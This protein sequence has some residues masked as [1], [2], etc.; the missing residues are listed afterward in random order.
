[1]GKTGG[2]GLFLEGLST[3]MVNPVGKMYYSRNFSYGK[4]NNITGNA[5]AIL[6]PIERLKFRSSFGLNAWFGHGRSWGPTYVLGSKYQ[7]NTD[8]ATQTMY[9]GS[10]IT[11]TNTL[12]YD[13]TVKEDHNFN[14]LVGSEMLK[15]QLNTNLGASKINTLFGHPDYAYLDNTQP[16]TTATD[17]S[18]WG[19]D[20]AA[21]GGGLL[22]YMARVS[23]NYKN[24]YMF[25]ATMRADGSS[26]FAEGNRWG[27]FPSASFG[28]NFTEEEFM[29]NVD[30]I[31]Y[32]KFR[33]SWGQN[34]N[35]NINNFVYSSNI[36][37]KQQ[38]YYLG[39]NKEVPGVAAVPANVPNP[40][41][42]W[43]TSE[44]LNFGIDARMFDSRMNVTFDWYNKVTK[45]WLVVAP[46]LGTF[47]A[48]APYVNGG[49]VRNRG[50][51]LSIGWNDNVGDFDYGITVSG[52]HNA[53]EV[54][55]LANAE[56]VINGSGSALAQN[57]SFVSRVEVGKPIGY[58][59]GFETDG[60][61]QNQEEVN[62]YVDA[63][64]NPIEIETE[65][66]KSRQPGDVRFV[67][68]NGDGVINDSDKVMIGS[69]QADL[70]L[71]I[72]LNASY[73]NFFFNTT[74]TG[75]FG[76]EVMQSYRSF[77]DRLTE[78]YTTAV[79][80]RWHGEGTSNT[81]PRLTYE[82]TANNLLISDLYVH[83]ADYLRISSL[84]F[85][86]RFGEGGSLIKGLN[87]ASVYVTL[88][89]LYTFT[90]YDGMDPE[91]GYGYYE[92]WASGIDLG[93]YPLPRTVIFGLTLNF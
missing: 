17:A 58:F 24:K 77:S 67:D 55:K 84:T 83:D 19:K 3:D 68:Q 2:Y 21:Q 20:W 93:L 88:N 59:Y 1:M 52:A 27:Y 7:N 90:K 57:T 80:D 46:I 49:D 54:T 9:Q 35:Q 60:I 45:D 40:D 44:Q 86:Y 36:G 39:G 8:S 28:W 63:S 73:K 29:K 30:F 38:G 33:A 47:G 74:L 25:D 79:F 50:V 56:G 62:A 66:G 10:D 18:A 13:F 91:V 65:K 34:G 32:G 14:V 61:F 76:Q 89:N 69:P 5:Y 16:A 82:A 41:V 22:S 37:Y 75:K 31:S 12:T 72:S 6:E 23:Y 85:G 4:G 26:N 71:G 70:E 53:N 42:T 11:W 15:H 48:S 92:S 64:G 43:E 81:M 51:E 87:G 78:N